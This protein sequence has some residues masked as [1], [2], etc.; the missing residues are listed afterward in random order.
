MANGGTA[1]LGSSKTAHGKL[2]FEA[3]QALEGRLPMTGDKAVELVRA[4][5]GSALAAEATNQLVRDISIPLTGGLEGREGGLPQLAADIREAS[6]K[7]DL[8]I[9]ELTR[10]LLD[11]PR[12]LRDVQSQGQ[13]SHSYLSRQEGSSGTGETANRYTPSRLSVIRDDSNPT[14]SAYRN[15]FSYTP[16]LDADN[17]AQSAAGTYSRH[18]TTGVEAVSPTRNTGYRQ[19]SQIDRISP[20]KVTRP[21]TSLGGIV[22]RLRSPKKGSLP[23]LDD[24]RSSTAGSPDI[25]ARGSAGQGGSTGRSALDMLRRTSVRDSS[26]RLRRVH[27]LDGG[28]GGRGTQSMDIARSDYA[29]PSAPPHRR[30]GS[31]SP[32]KESVTSDH[33]ATTSLRAN[34]VLERDDRIQADTR[35]SLRKKASIIS[36]NTVRAVS[37]FAPG[38]MS[39]LPP[40]T[41]ATSGISYV[42]AGDISPTVAHHRDVP[43]GSGSP[44]HPDSARSAHSYK[45]SVDPRFGDVRTSLDEVESSSPV[46]RYGLANRKTRMPDLDRTDSGATARSGADD[47]EQGMRQLGIGRPAAPE[48]QSDNGDRLEKSKLARLTSWRLKR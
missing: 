11:L 44:M 25:D 20:S 5:K 19:Q 32:S 41:P 13:Q 45:S 42:T 39:K 36:T 8:A 48:E 37:G 40:A 31:Y 30:A 14:S 23:P 33:T 22:A 18:G 10:V 12:L 26:S 46:S 4:V 38:L 27:E 47:L 34:G 35:Q 24:A 17:R 9:R 15:R 16:S 3:A 2:L 1:L 29:S 28:S 43:R 21:S 7:S 6:K